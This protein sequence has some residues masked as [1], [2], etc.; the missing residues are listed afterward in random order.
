M[1][2]ALVWVLSGVVLYSLVAMALSARGMLPDS[3]RVSGPITTL[4]T[5]RG[6]A[7]LDRLAAPK[8]FW[9]AWANVGVGITL[10]VMIGSF[11][12][13]ILSAVLIFNRPESTSI[14]QPRSFLVIPGV[15]PFLP[16]SVAPEIVFG[17]LV[18]LVIHE[19]GHGL[20]CR[21]EGID[22]SSMGLALVTLI[23]MGAFVEPDEE[24][25]RNAARGAQT[26]MFAAGVT[27]NFA[28]TAIAF[29]L[30]FGPVV[31][32][33]AVAPGV[34]VG[35]ALPGTP[36]DEAGIGQGDVITAVAGHN[37]TNESQ[38]EHALAST[39]R[40]AEV[41]LSDGTTTTVRRSLVVTSA[42]R[43]GPTGLDIN[44]TITAVNGTHVRTEHAFSK[45]LE[46]TT[47]AT[48]QTADG[49]E[50]TAPMGAYASKIIPDGPLANASGQ[51]GKSVIVTRFAGERI[52]DTSELRNVLS[53]TQPGDVVQTEV[54]SNGE[55]ATYRVQLGENPRT[56]SGL[57]GVG[58]LQPGT[59]GLVV[60]DLG[61][62]TYPAGAFLAILGG[63][64]GSG[65]GS[66]LG[67]L[68]VS[69]F[70]LVTLPF[71]SVAIPGA[72]YNF[73]GFVG[74]TLDY[75]TVA[76][77]PLSFLGGSVFVLA[78]VL[79]WTGWVNINLAI[80]NCIPAFPLDGGH[81]LRTSTEAI[82]SRLPVGSRGALTG[83]I[84]TAVS[85][86]MLAALVVML[87]GPTLLT[88]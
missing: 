26:R 11:L 14:S 85:L 13:V 3:V 19:G 47:V 82:V 32:S 16:L 62:D 2:S 60:D 17:L 23:P 50:T 35:G 4:H 56:G 25:Q 15:N 86:T 22:I 84:T 42:T 52:T 12:L 77:G 29:A 69:V 9:R 27:N 87:F 38:L 49:T 5:E 54:Y 28:I 58:G 34:P 21:V 45:V 31:G 53:R 71:A 41:T 64:G 68:F 10:V 65:G 36:A 6:K 63:E 46:N 30:L 44:T 20:L 33:I 39:D 18:G 75:Y 24:Q 37:V 73:A 83:T 8:R 51:G 66:M 55:R 80:F 43:G 74:P 57:L 88:G 40:T 1:V 59:S 67:P 78:N 48:L 72:N 81:I 7:V 76:G 79:F 61:I 70:S